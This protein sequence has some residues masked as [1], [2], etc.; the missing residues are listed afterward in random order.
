MFSYLSIYENEYTFLF[1]IIF[2]FP[3]IHYIRDSNAFR[4]LTII[5]INYNIVVHSHEIQIDKPTD[6]NRYVVKILSINAVFSSLVVT[7]GKIQS[8]SQQ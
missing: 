4:S 6:F 3:K 7:L 1:I 5:A 2:S 8:L